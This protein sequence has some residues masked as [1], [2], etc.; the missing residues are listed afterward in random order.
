MEEK[1]KDWRIRL[2]VGQS[3]WVVGISCRLFSFSI[4]LVFGFLSHSLV[5]EVSSPARID[6]Y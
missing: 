4:L 6:E 5:S 1:E 3:D 2:M